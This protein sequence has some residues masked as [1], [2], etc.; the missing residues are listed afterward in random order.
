MD[1]VLVNEAAF[2]AISETGWIEENP[3]LPSDHGIVWIALDR[4]KLKGNNHSKGKKQQRETRN[5][6][7]R[8]K[9]AQERT[10]EKYTGVPVRIMGSLPHTTKDSHVAQVLLDNEYYP[11]LFSRHCKHK[12][13]LQQR[14]IRRGAGTTDSP[15]LKDCV[16]WRN[17][18][19]EWWIHPTDE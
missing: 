17:D 8:L 9:G 5:D 2:D 16:K 4:S 18:K 7:I 19:K 3:F 6:N 10:H 12:E 1:H 13:E 11:E 15:D 14:M